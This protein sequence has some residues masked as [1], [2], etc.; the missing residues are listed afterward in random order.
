[1]DAQ[2]LGRFNEK[3]MQFQPFSEEKLRESIIPDHTKRILALQKSRKELRKL[4]KFP[5]AD[6]IRSMSQQD[7]GE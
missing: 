4:P 6:L 1:M 3:K 5:D 2:R 7:E